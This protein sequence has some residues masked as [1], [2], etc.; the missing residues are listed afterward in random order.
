MTAATWHRGYDEGV[1]TTLEPYP[2][3]TLLD[4]LAEAA[5]NWPNRPALLFKGSKD[6]LPP[7]RGRERFAGGG[8]GRDRRQARRPRRPVPA[9]LPAVH[10]R[11]VRGVEGRSDRVPVQSDLQ[12]PRDGRSASRHGRRDSRRAES[13]LREGEG[14]SVDHLAQAHRR[15]EHQGIPSAAPS[16]RVH[17]A[18]GEEGGRPHHAA[19]RRPPVRPFGAAFQ[20]GPAPRG[21]CLSRRSVCHSDERRHDGHSEGSR[22]PAPRN[23]DRRSPASVVASAG[24]EGM[25][26][27]DHVAAA[28]LSHLRQH[29]RAESG[30]HQPQSDRAHSKSREISAIC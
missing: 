10:D 25:D 9:E 14:N 3:R 7:A 2:E 18:Q 29:R 30:A 15:H 6:H 12:R 27:H 22:R 24:N 1:P 4:Y 8:A 13:I 23:G 16:A 28:A 5:R 21:T 20:L 26:R 19:R 11:G 17:A